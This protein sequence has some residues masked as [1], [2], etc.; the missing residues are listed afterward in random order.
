MQWNPTLWRG[1]IYVPRIPNQPRISEYCLKEVPVL[2][3][4]VFTRS[5]LWVR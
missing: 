1:N 3:W 2:R 4:G 5:V